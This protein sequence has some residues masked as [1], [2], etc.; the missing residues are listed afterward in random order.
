MS[1]GPLAMMRHMHA[2]DAKKLRSS[3]VRA[4]MNLMD[5]EMDAALWQDWILFYLHTV[6][7]NWVLLWVMLA[8]FCLVLI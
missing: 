7:I 3:M 2:L 5:D 6:T 1:F 4:W 8:R